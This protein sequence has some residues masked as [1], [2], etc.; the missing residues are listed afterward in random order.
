MDELIINNFNYFINNKNNITNEQI[1]ELISS[2]VKYYKYV[3]NVNY[4]FRRE[5]M[6]F[7]NNKKKI[8]FK[9]R[10]NK[11]YRSSSSQ[12]TIIN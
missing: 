12:L 10:K 1:Y 6:I 2:T 8:N 9:N 3:Y 11:N 5:H 4:D 7:Q